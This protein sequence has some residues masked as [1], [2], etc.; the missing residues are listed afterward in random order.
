MIE[1][2][3]ITN[4]VDENL[5]LDES[6]CMIMKTL[7]FFSLE[8]GCDLPPWNEAGEGARGGEGE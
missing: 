5:D 1:M 4:S 2:K 7:H 6:T 3:L 8:G